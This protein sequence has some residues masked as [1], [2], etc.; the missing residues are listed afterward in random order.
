MMPQSVRPLLRYVL[1]ELDELLDE[2]ELVLHLLIS[3]WHSTPR[4]GEE[5]LERKM[6]DIKKS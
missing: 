3:F 6:A 2:V 4:T 1:G 5:H